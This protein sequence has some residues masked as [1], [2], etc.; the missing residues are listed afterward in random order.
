[1]NFLNSVLDLPHDLWPGQ[2][3]GS[4]SEP[5]WHDASAVS[6]GWMYAVYGSH[7][8]GLS[9]G[10]LGLQKQPGGEEM[11]KIPNI[12]MLIFKRL[13]P[14]LHQHHF[15]SL[16]T[17]H[18]VLSP[19]SERNSESIFF[20]VHLCRPIRTPLGRNNIHTLSSCPWVTCCVSVTVSEARLLRVWLISGL[21]WWAW[22]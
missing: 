5:H 22:L 21:P 13:R 8:S 9:F 20:L 2:R 7:A 12:V 17:F 16:V 3:S 11:N 1:M 18:I 10:L 4:N 6:L 15:C 14:K 19:S